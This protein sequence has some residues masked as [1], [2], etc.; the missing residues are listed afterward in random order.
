MQNLTGWKWRFV[1]CSLVL[2]LLNNP[3]VTYNKIFNPKGDYR[4]PKIW[5]PYLHLLDHYSTISLLEKYLGRYRYPRVSG[6]MVISGLIVSNA[7]KFLLDSQP[8]RKALGGVMSRLSTQERTNFGFRS[9][10][11]CYFI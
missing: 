1:V 2:T 7:S 4:K 10:L 5:R 9:G 6:C 11:G 3:Y 8:H